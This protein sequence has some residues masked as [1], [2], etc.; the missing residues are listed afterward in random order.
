M[1]AQQQA[2]TW[3]PACPSWCDRRHRIEPVPVGNFTTHSQDVGSDMETG[4][5]VSV[6]GLQHQDGSFAQQY[7]YVEGAEIAISDPQEAQRFANS[8]ALA[9]VILAQVS[10]QRR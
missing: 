9:A 2:E 6:E 4:W 3:M 8:V 10:P 5:T 1:S 7:V